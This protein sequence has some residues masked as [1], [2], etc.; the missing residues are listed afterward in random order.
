RCQSPSRCTNA[1]A[2]VTPSGVPSAR[3]MSN[4]SFGSWA[5]RGCWI[6]PLLQSRHS[7]TGALSTQ[8]A[9]DEDIVIGAL[10]EPRFAQTRFLDEAAAPEETVGAL[11]ERFAPGDN[12][13][14]IPRRKAGVDNNRH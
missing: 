7:W 14:E 1:R 3:T 9:E 12:P 8:A 2:L 11:V 10:H 6:T 5:S 13:L 4:S